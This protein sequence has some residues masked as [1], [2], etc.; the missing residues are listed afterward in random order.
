MS[1]TGWTCDVPT[2]TCT[3]A[4]CSRPARSIRRSRSRA[5]SLRPPPASV[6]NLASVC[7]RRRCEPHEQRRLRPDHDRPAAVPADR[8]GRRRGSVGADAGAVSSCTDSGG[9]CSDDYDD[10][11]VVTLTATAG[12]RRDLRRLGRRV[13]RHRDTCQVTMDQARNAVATFTDPRARPDDREEPQ[14]H[15]HPG[16]HRQLH[17]HRLQRRRR[18]PRPAQ[19]RSPSS[20]PPA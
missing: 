20:R 4:T 14:R 10:G 17:A 7:G 6:T 3:R 8:H 19:S 9:D 5:R 16:R 2:A 18:A 12:R 15:V 11:T 13:Q 1:G